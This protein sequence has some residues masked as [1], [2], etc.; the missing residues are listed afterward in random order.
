MATEPAKPRFLNATTHGVEVTFA[1][2]RFRRN[3]LM[4]PGAPW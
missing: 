3:L 4:R 2:V 1:F